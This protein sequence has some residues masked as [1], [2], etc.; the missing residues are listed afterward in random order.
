[1][2]NLIFTQTFHEKLVCH[3]FLR[4]YD[5]QF[6]IL[7]AQ[8]PKDI[9]VVLHLCSNRSC[10]TIL[11]DQHLTEAHVVAIC[12]S[13]IIRL[14]HKL[15]FAFSPYEATSIRLAAIAFF[16]HPIADMVIRN[17]RVLELIKQWGNE[18]GL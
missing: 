3:L 17:V 16:H 14:P 1:M 10:D 7:F 6:P 11:D 8:S 4:L 13:G 9:L 15:P 12:F 18:E 2:S 5:A